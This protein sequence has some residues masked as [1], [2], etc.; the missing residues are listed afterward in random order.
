MSRTDPALFPDAD[1]G[2]GPASNVA[3]FTVSEISGALKRTIEDAFGHVRLRGEVSGYRGPHASG[4]AYF[5]PK[6][7]KARIDAVIW[8]T[9]FAKLA[10]KPE[11]GLEI[12]ATGRLTTYPG[13]SKYQIVIED[14]RPAGAGALMALL[15]ERRQM[16]EA[17]G[18]FA[19]ARKKPLPFL[20]RIVGVVTSP[21]GAVIRDICHRIADRFPVHVLVW[22]VKVQGEGSGDQVAA[23]ISGFNAL[24]DKSK[25][26]RPDV[27]IVARGGGSLE[28]LWGFNDEAVVRAAAASEIPLISAVGHETDWTLID[29]AADRRAPTPTGAAEMA[30]PVKAELIAD[31]AG[32]HARLGQAVTRRLDQERRLVAQ[33]AR[34]LPTADML[35]ALPR[36]RLDEAASSLN[37]GFRVLISER[38][39]AFS[40]AAG[41]LS[42]STLDGAV[43][44]KRGA[45]RQSGAEADHAMAALLAR[46]RAAYQKAASVIQPMGVSALT[47]AARLRLTALSDRLARAERDLTR[48]RRDQLAN[49][50]RVA[51]GLGPQKVLARGY[52]IVRD[53]EDRPVTD[54]AALDAGAVLS[55]E[56]AGGKRIGA[57]ATT[58]SED[59]ATGAFGSR[60]R[61]KKPVPQEREQG[62][63]F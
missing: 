37:S 32:L 17:E 26:P 54:P 46:R 60:K 3:E 41:R 55:L 56:F 49:I 53:R 21:T 4:H 10:F 36:R 7:D 8:R 12:V 31:V 11:E 28:D 39:Q 1:P 9:S 25:V 43:R 52:A 14:V 22:P 34:A 38:R 61:R 35:L 16:L 24:S 30:V 47:K 59:G 27:I 40:A 51:S 20:P 19:E 29:H 58:G 15:N 2:E 6:D 44:D 48:M 62:D 63:L 33:T 57:I 23:A 5:S 50:W 45:L 18:L 42:L 13:S